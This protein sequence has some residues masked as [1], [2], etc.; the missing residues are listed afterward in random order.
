MKQTDALLLAAILLSI[1]GLGGFAYWIE[2]QPPREIT[3]DQ[4]NQQPENT[5]I[6]TNATIKT[7][8]FSANAT[9]IELSD[10]NA[11]IKATIQTILNQPVGSRVQVIGKIRKTSSSNRLELVD[12]KPI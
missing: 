2:Q 1:L 8:T 3:L 4:I 9:S 5:L 6:Q 11:S 10:Q 7:K 12:V